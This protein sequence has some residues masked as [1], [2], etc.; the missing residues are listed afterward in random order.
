MPT[1]RENHPAAPALWRTTRLQAGVLALG[2]L[3]VPACDDDSE[4]RACTTSEAAACLSR[5]EACLVAGGQPV[6]DAC[7]AGEHPNT[8]GVCVAFTGT[9]MT[10]TFGP[11]DLAAG[12]EIESVCESWTLGN[13]EDIFVNAAELAS[14]G[15]FHHSILFFVPEGFQDWPAGRWED[16]YEKGFSEVQAAVAG[17]VLVASST[18][19]DG[20]MQQFPAGVA[21]RIP[22]GSRIIAALHLKNEGTTPLQTELRSAFHTV[23]AATV[24]TRLAPSQLV[25][26]GL[27][28]PTDKPSSFGGTCDLA[29]AI[30]PT[31]AV[32]VHGFLP[33]LHPAATSLQVAV[34]GGPQDGRVLVELG[35]YE[36][37]TL[38]FVF[39]PPVDLTGATGLSMRCNYDPALADAASW[40]HGHEEKCETLIYVDSPT[41]FAGF[42]GA[43]ERPAANADGDATWPCVVQPFA[44]PSVAP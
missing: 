30:G 19:V 5:H 36:P 14:D 3:A 34:V 6:C 16:C 24:T 11:Y 21:I 29:T 28:I 15:G 8:A 10:Q 38:G 31:M 27:E 4:A 42:I 26:P 41:A 18:E 32:K 39:D 13:T 12:G 22:A 40:G 2:L 7:P 37:V 1:P 33:H 25:V 17:G 20:E 43:T 35:P 44:Y 9:P 23:D